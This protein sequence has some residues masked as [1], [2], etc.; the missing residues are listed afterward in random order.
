MGVIDLSYL[1]HLGTLELAASSAAS[2]VMRI[3]GVLL[4]GATGTLNTLCSQALG[5]RN[6]HLVG[7]WLQTSL[8]LMTIFSIVIMVRTDYCVRKMQPAI[9]GARR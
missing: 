9:N 4:W 8:V 5:T 6:Y 3:T 1:G 2:I 7:I